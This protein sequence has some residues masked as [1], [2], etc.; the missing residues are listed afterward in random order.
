MLNSLLKS[1]AISVNFILGLSD[2]SSFNLS[3]C[4]SVTKVFFT[5]GENYIMPISYRSNS[6]SFGYPNNS[7]NSSIILPKSIDKTG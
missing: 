1:K 6:N 4:L 3:A 7:L 5:V 2:I